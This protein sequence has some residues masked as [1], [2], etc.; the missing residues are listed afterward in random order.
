LPG[1]I[2]FW[3]HTQF[4]A[5]RTPEKAR[6]TL[7]DLDPTEAERQTTF[8]DAPDGLYRFTA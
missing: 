5:V 8:R 6:K 3:P 4:E 2:K 7:D 1:P